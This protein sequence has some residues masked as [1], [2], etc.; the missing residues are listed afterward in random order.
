MGLDTFQTH[1]YPDFNKAYD[2]A[3]NSKRSH[4]PCFANKDALAFITIGR[5]TCDRD[6][7]FYFTEII[8]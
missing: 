7:I 4:D 2:S 8:G 6:K 3:R 5:E 1:P